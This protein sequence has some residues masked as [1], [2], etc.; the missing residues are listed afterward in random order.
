MGF[1][2]WA[3]KG[4]KEKKYFVFLI[5]NSKGEIGCAV[6]IKSDYKDMAEVGYWASIDSPGLVT[7]ALIKV[8]ELAKVEGY[9]RLF[10]LVMTDNTKSADVAKRAGFGEVGSEEKE[11]KKYK[12]LEKIL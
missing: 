1:V 2:E 3:T 6:D 10:A 7:N 5:R 8:C 12:R 11:G 9:K 4:W